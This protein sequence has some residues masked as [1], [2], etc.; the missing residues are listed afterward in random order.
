MKFHAFASLDSTSTHAQR[1]LDESLEEPPFA[2]WSASQTQGR[3]RMGRSWLSPDGGL[4]LTLVLSAKEISVA[5]QAQLP[6]A[7]ALTVSRWLRARFQ[8]RVTIKWPNDLLFG[9]AKLCG[10]LCEGRIQGDRWGPALIGVGINVIGLAPRVPEQDTIS[11]EEIKGKVLDADIEELARDLAAW[12]QRCLG[13][14][15]SHEEY[16]EFALEPGQIWVE[17]N[18]ATQLARLRPLSSRGN[19]M[20]QSLGSGQEWEVQTIHHG[21][22]WL[23]QKSDAARP[24]LIADIGNSR[25]KVG[26]FRDALDP[27]AEPEILSLNLHRDEAAIQQELEGFLVSKGLPKAWP[28]H[29]ISVQDQDIQVLTRLVRRVGLEICPVPKRPLRVDFSQYR[30]DQLGIDRIALVEAGRHLYPAQNLILLSAGTAVTVEVL[31]AE[32]VYWGGYILSGLQTRLDALHEK[33]SKLPL[34]RLADLYDPQSLY[35][36]KLLGE[37]TSTAI[38]RGVLREITW[39]MQGLKR[40]LA[41]KDP[42]RSWQVCVSGGGAE[43]LSKLLDVPCQPSLILKGVRLFV[44]GGLRT[45]DSIF[46]ES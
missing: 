18:N 31:S 30:L 24:L 37:D 28:L 33:T 3:G 40:D 36:E 15:L 23:Y 2:V 21:W 5:N 46:T 35:G 8:L 25:C 1:L 27:Q 7:V 39:M 12:L 43:L 41:E 14:D 17:E 34:L 45:R 13:E 38:L 29:V 10:I 44:L 19:M 22:T 4:Y 26:Y 16:E 9:A 32:D 42:S 20:L 6:L 11:L